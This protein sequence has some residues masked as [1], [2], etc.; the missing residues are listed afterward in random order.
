MQGKTYGDDEPAELTATATGLVGEDALDYSVARATGEAAGDYAITITLGENPNYN[1]TKT[2]GTFTIAPKAVTLAVDEG[3]GKTYGDEEPAELTATATG[4]VGE[5]ALDYSIA[6]A[7]GEA[8]GDYAITIT[9]GE[10]PNYNVTKTDGTFTIAPKA[11]TLAVDEGQGK[12]Y[13]DDE[14]AELT[15]TASGL[16]GEDA[17]DYSVARATGEAA[18]DYAV[19]ITLGE[20]PNYSVTKTD[21]TFTIAPKAATLKASNLSKTYGQKDPTLTAISG[22]LAGTDKLDY[23]LE[24]AE[25]ENAGEYVITVTPGNNPNY[26]VTVTNGTFTIGRKALTIRVNDQLDYTY[27]AEP[28]GENNAAYSNADKVTVTGL[29]GDDVLT[30][31]TLNGQAQDVRLDAEGN[32]IAYTGRILASGAVIGEATDNYDITYRAGNLKIN[33]AGVTLTANSDETREYTGV[34]QSVEGF[35]CSVEGLTFEG[36]SA[37]ASGI[38]AGSYETA[39]SGVTLNRTMDSTG[40]YVVTGTTEGKLVISP[41]DVTVDI[42]GH[43]STADYNGAEHSVSG[44]DV[45]IGNDLYKETDFTFSGSRT[46]AR[47]EAG[48]TNMGLAADQFENTNPNFA[49][50]TFHVTDGWQT[51]NP[52]DAEVTITGHTASATYDG[53]GHSVS[54][55]EVEIGN[56]LYTEADFTFS[57]NDSADRIDEGRTGMGLDADQFTNTNPNFANVTFNVTDG[58]QEI[59]PVD[60]VVVT[61]TGH[62][63]TVDYDATGHSVS[64]YDVAISNSLYTEADFTFSG[65]AEAGRTEAG[66]TNMGLAAEQFANTNSNFTKVVFNVTDGAQTVAPI[67]A[68]VTITGHTGT[69]DYDGTE[70]SVTGYDVSIA[71]DSLYTAEDFAFTGTDSIARTD[72]G[73]SYMNLA[74]SQF[75]N[76]NSNFRTVTFH[77][78]DGW[79]TISPIDA[80][81]TIVGASSTAD[82]DG[83]AHMVSGYTATA[84]SDLYD[85]E[86]DF[87]FSGSST[88][89][90]TDAGTT[91]MGLA[92]GQFTNI[93][94]NF[95]TVTFNVTDGRQTI[96]PIKAVV[97]IIGA[98]NSA[99]FDGSE[100]TVNGYTAKADTALYNVNSDFTF[101]G[102]AA[103]VRTDEGTTAMGLTADRFENTNGNFSDV[104]FRVTDGGQTITKRSVKVTITEHSGDVTYDGEEHT[105]SGYDVSISDPLYTEADFSFSGNDSV[106]GRDA[107]SYDMKLNAK[108]FTNNN[109]N[110]RAAFAIVDGRQV[111]RPA[112]VT[113]AITGHQATAVYDRKAHTAEGYNAEISNALYTEDDFI[114]SGSST[115][116]RADAG[117]TNMGLAAEQFRNINPNFKAAFTAVD[118]FITIEPIGEVKV[119]ITGHTGSNTFDG[120]EH[121][122]SGYD[123]EISDGA[124]TEADFAFSGTADAAGTNAGTVHMGLAAD[125]FANLNPNI[126][127]VIFNVTDGW[128]K[129]DPATATVTITG[130][131]NAAVYDGEEHSVSGY[132]TGIDNSLYRESDFSFSGT[133]EAAQTEAGT[134]KMGLTAEQFVNTNANFSNVTFN[135]TDGYQTITAADEVVVTITGHRSTQDYDGEEH[136]VTGY[137]VDISNPLYSE[138]DF[139]FAGGNAAANRTDAGTTYMGLTADQFT[140]TSAN[141]EKVTFEVT[142]GWQTIAPI[143]ATVTITGANG[144]ADYD[145]TAHTVSGYTAEA[146]TGL[147]DVTKDFTFSGMAEAARTDAGTA[148]MGLKADQFANVSENFSTVTFNVTDGWQ[149]IDPIDATVTI[150]GANSTADYDGTVHTVSGF[151]A[152]ADNELYD[153]AKD[154]IFDGNRTAARVDAGTTDM[155]L[156]ADQFSNI[157]QNFRIVTFDV[158]DGW[159]TIDPID[160]T[161][162][163]TGHSDRVTYNAREQTVA[164]YDAE[165]SNDLYKASD[166]TFSGTGSVSGTN[167]GTYRMG[168]KPSDFT[169]TNANFANVTFAVTDGSLVIRRKAVTIT[170]DSKTRYYGDADPV[171]TVT[172]A[173][174]EGSDVI[175]AT[176]SREEGEN[177]GEYR[178]TVSATPDKNY[179]IGT[180]PGK[181]TIEPRPV[182]VTAENKVKVFGTADPA[183]TATVEGLAEG[184]TEDLITYELSREAGETVGEYAISVTGETAQGNYAVTCIPGTLEIVT[185]DTVIV[186]I[187]GSNESFRYD[188]TMKEISG[189]GVEISS[190]LYTEADFTFNGSSTVSG[191]N[192][193]TYSTNMTAGDFVNTNPNFSKVRFEITNSTLKITRRNI[194]LTSGDAEKHYDGTPLTNTEV[195]ETGDGFVEGEGVNITVTGRRTNEGESANTFIYAM[196]GYTLADNYN[197][198]PVYGTL[199]VTEV[200]GELVE[201]HKLTITYQY[202]DGTLIKTFEKEYMTGKPYSVTSDKI[203]SYA[204]DTQV[205]KGYM[206]TEDI[207]ITVTYTATTHTLTVYFV[208]ILDG[209][210]VAE[211][212]TLQL[213][214]GAAYTIYVPAV[215]GYMSMADKVYGTMPDHDQSIKV[216]LTPEGMENTLEGGSGDYAPIE[217][218]DFGTPLGVADTILGGGEVI[219]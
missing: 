32:V 59:V 206:G 58:W 129:I 178:I 90:R 118:G 25:G 101:T 82:Y 164:G 40:N 111:I 52:I 211:P 107:G 4:L 60:E 201:Y 171:L 169:N 15:A 174:L 96:E 80:V 30:G 26:D 191:M 210:P 116:A 133:A 24:R 100:H 108:D 214:N 124:Y 215:E 196:A 175:P 190:P 54:G 152:M 56:S 204:P 71:E 86:K 159:Q 23:T 9:L 154:F 127:D 66:T 38:S 27:N 2:D 6:R 165:I 55:Y 87:T 115:A 91:D 125:Q 51:I 162:T 147:Y 183:L 72:A 198:T 57:G 14:P 145:G 104:T 97:T 99:T 88:A 113:V 197:I 67:D 65:T 187:T 48:T 11:V 207:S 186:K 43:S 156:A 19:T 160:V 219:E 208:S 199:K 10:N 5:D 3:Q 155:G 46:A 69:A 136:G 182:T 41:I 192:A 70:H 53:T 170:A 16:V 132:E 146:D 102:T 84:D 21:G 184:E 123:V 188:G 33:P 181:L 1:V 61:I 139:I 20:N 85:V 68:E 135:V 131:H 149:T 212:A 140:N 35:T 28:H 185:D 50:V 138:S 166:F 194:T 168:L 173:G 31:I 12:T 120:K 34:K 177:V 49:N 218:E 128:Q 75:E 195:V 141:F 179:V 216:F 110:F 81:V 114:F 63:S 122:V 161:V 213:N 176:L 47:T 200:E 105:V 89:L 153:A 158:T 18:G 144:T 22:G 151:T 39:F 93:N 142:D 119:T 44:Y 103:A 203:A 209:S 167:A 29:V 193:G 8:A 74:S 163:I 98:K 64:G 13:G 217:I 7:T 150:V 79:Q 205:V 121:G 134:A 42:T 126:T 106:T 76:R 202:E 17:L 92:A 77:V 78:T 45:S 143:A 157:N 62:R 94:A 95:A 172:T 73:T 130:H 189:Y 117:T 37:G 180:V 137:D 112:D 109:G 36:V 83:S 148:F